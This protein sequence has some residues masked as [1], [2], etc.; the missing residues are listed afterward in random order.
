MLSRNLRKLSSN[1]LVEETKSNK[2]PY[3]IDLFQ[4]VKDWS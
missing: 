1:H 3:A 2:N 4:K